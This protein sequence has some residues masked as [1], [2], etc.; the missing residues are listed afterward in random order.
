MSG[1]YWENVLNR[2]VLSRRKA[3]ALAS[4]GLTGAALAAACGG[5]DS[6]GGGGSS[7]NGGGTSSAE[8]TNKTDKG[9]FTPSDGSPQQGGRFTDMESGA[10]GN[11]NVVTNWTEGTR[12]GGIFVYDRPLTS[13]EDERR[14]VL[15]G[16]ESIE[17]KDPLT[18]V[19]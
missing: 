10:S 8:E 14:Y 9:E 11:F 13:R 2:R 7:T 17:L 18:L 16:M 1:S 3:L 5:G 12:L 6:G 19:M 15:E 4:T